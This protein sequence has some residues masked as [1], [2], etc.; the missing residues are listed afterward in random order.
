M[1]TV[2]PNNFI[3]IA[4]LLLILPLLAACS[5]VNVRTQPAEA[6]SDIEI[7]EPWA[8]SEQAGEN[9]AAYMEIANSG[10]V[11]DRLLG[12]STDIAATVEIHEI[13]ADGQMMRMQEVDAIEIPA[14]ETV[15][16]EPG[17]LHVMFFD[18]AETLEPGD[19]FMLTLQFE[20]AG[21]IDIEV[22]VRMHSRGHGG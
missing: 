12:A 1:K 21:D 19:Q 6:S 11:D 14:G 22:N 20:H 2:T 17:G 16:L 7:A 10:D 3:R 9:S 18:L 15:V 8:R 4:A 5:S 13:V